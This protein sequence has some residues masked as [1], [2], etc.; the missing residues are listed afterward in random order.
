MEVKNDISPKVI[1]AN[2][3][4][5]VVSL[6]AL[7]SPQAGEAITNAAQF[8]YHYWEI[9]ITGFST[10]VVLRPEGTLSGSFG[11]IADDGK[12][13]TLTADGIFFIDTT[14]GRRFSKVRLTWV[15][16]AATSVAISY[17]GGN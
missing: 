17:R 4:S 14:R 16:G 5:Q 11:T 15:S 8:R 3:F 2:L 7:S 9:I 12:D 6:T 13:I 1:D 10:D